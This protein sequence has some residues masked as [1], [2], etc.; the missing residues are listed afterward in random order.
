[1][2]LTKEDIIN[3]VNRKISQINSKEDR[4]VSFLGIY[5]D[6]IIGNQTRLILKCNIHNT[7]WDTTT[8]IDNF[9]H[10][11]GTIGCP[12]CSNFFNRETKVWEI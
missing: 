1:M 8:N 2:K 9:I 12:I 6:N 11:D 10:R 4:N 7:I 5:Q 3:N